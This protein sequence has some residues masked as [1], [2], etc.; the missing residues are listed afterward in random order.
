MP[1][2]PKD[3]SWQAV[4]FDFD[5][6]IADTNQ[7][8]GQAFVDMY[9]SHG[10]EIIDAIIAFHLAN[11]GMARIRKI[12]YY[13]REL[14]HRDSDQETLDALEQEFSR[15]VI[16]KVV[17][18]DFIP[19]A[20]ESLKQLKEQLVPAFVVSGT[21]HEEMQVV[22]KRKGLEQYFCEVHGSPRNK[23]DIVTDLLDRYHLNPAHCIFIGDAMADYTAA[24]NT[25][26]YFQGIQSDYA[27]LLFPGDPTL[28]PTVKVD[29]FYSL[30]PS[31]N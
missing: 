19:G 7:I 28:S 26:L 9:A 2:L 6:V 21:P 8:K 18:A 30:P 24:T 15:R 23:T 16:D 4:F 10:K 14:V 5:G 11:G 13:Q 22:V 31:T 27:P 12:E 20:L 25:G 1:Q 17:A 29:G 3:T